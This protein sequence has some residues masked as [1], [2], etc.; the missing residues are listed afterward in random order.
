MELVEVLVFRVLLDF[1]HLKMS[2]Q[3]L[4]LLFLFVVIIMI[5]IFDGHRVAVFV[6]LE[7]YRRLREPLRV[8]SA[9]VDT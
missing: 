1:M 2:P 3:Y 5:I 8:L 7:V 9:I 4:F 6:L